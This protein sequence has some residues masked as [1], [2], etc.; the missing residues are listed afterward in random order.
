ML[1]FAHQVE[2]VHVQLIESF[3]KSYRCHCRHCRPKVSSNSI[4]VGT[5]IGDC[6]GHIKTSA[7]GNTLECVTIETILEIRI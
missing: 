4:D 5:G 3:E 6:R 1:M 7:N 2:D